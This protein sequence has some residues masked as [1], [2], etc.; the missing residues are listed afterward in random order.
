MYSCLNESQTFLSQCTCYSHIYHVMLFV[1]EDKVSLQYYYQCC[2][3]DINGLP[4]D[5]R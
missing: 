3:G 1:K 5:S 4:V 2:M